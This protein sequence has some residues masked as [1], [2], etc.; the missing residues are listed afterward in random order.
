VPGAAAGL[1][2]VFAD[3]SVWRLEVESMDPN[4]RQRDAA[5]FLAMHQTPPI[6][7]LPNAWD[8]ISARIFESEG[9]QAIAT[10]SAGVA[11]TLGY[12][13]GQRMSLAE[14][15]GVVRRIVDGVG[16]PVSADIEAG[17]ARSP[18]GVAESVRVTLE[19][20][21]VGV[22]IEDGTG[23]PLTPLFDLPLQIEKIAAARQM[24]KAQGVHVVI[25][26]RT[27]VYL[28]CE[29]APAALFRLAVDRA[30]AYREAG[31]D[32]VFVPDTGKLDRKTIAL[33]VREIDAPLNIIAGGHTPPILELEELGVARVT[34]GPRPMRAA[35]AVLRNI[36]RE[37]ARSGTYELMTRETL[38]Y[39]DVNRLLEPGR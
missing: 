25:N 14:N 29:D 3:L 31:A 11:A 26:A 30:N 35:L 1:V 32:C 24:A 17:Y 37:L 13:D 23:M 12:P 33:L 38:S 36:A 10:T 4:R 6:L 18:E 7:V 2:S 21:A 39:A 34:V 16:V 8:V 9:F 15:L 20:G 28:S 27:D 19:T 5:A 22:N